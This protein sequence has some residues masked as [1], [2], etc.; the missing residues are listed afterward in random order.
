ME[1]IKIAWKRIIKTSFL[2]SFTGILFSILSYHFFDYIRLLTRKIYYIKLNTWDLIFLGTNVVFWGAMGYL[3]NKEIVK[4][5]WKAT[6]IYVTLTLILSVAEIFLF[7]LL[8]TKPLY[9]CGT[10]CC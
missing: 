8:F 5:H 2:S 1:K 6:I 9:L 3:V 4:S 7:I 10:K